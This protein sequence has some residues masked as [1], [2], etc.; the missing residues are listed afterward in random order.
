MAPRRPGDAAVLTAQIMRA[1][2]V[3]GFVAQRSSIQQ[4][5]EDAVAWAIALRN[6]Q[7][8]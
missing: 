2:H 6:R 3:L 4:I 7:Q 5:V 8:D 1:R